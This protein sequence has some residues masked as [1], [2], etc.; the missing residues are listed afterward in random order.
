VKVLTGFSWF[1]TGSSVGRGNKLSGELI[2]NLRIL[3]LETATGSIKILE[4]FYLL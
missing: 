1:R 2:D 4:E 3:R